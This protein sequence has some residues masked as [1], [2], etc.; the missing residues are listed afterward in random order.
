MTINQPASRV[1]GLRDLFLRR[2]RRAH[3]GGDAGGT[4]NSDFTAFTADL[5]SPTG[6]TLYLVRRE[7]A[8]WRARRAA[9]SR[10]TFATAGLMTASYRLGYSQW[11]AS[12]PPVT[13]NGQKNAHAADPE[14]GDQSSG[15]AIPD[16]W[17]GGASQNGCG[18]SINQRNSEVFA[19]WFT[20]GARSP[21]TWFIISS[22]SW[23]GNTLSLSLFRVTGS[24]WLGVAYQ[25]SAVQTSNAGTATLSFSDRANGQFGY[26]T[27]VANGNKPIRPP[28][29]SRG[30]APGQSVRDGCRTPARTPRPRSAPTAGFETPSF[31]PRPA[32]E[33]A[34]SATPT[35]ESMNGRARGARVLVPQT[36]RLQMKSSTTTRLIG[37]VDEADLLVVARRQRGE[38]VDSKPKSAAKS[39]PAIPPIIV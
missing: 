17:W 6:S 26:F 27:G 15:L 39:A 38:Q 29:V 19:A 33:T 21:P 25:P 8:S 36:R 18:I 13:T 4:W 2:H 16:M 31:P 10:F 32:E 23:S 14:R 5:Y 34:S 7:P 28:G 22:S 20:Y 30:S 1:F 9:R 12:G 35:I 3:V 11:D 24:P 37:H